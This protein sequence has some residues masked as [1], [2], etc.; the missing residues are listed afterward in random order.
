MLPFEGI[1]IIVIYHVNRVCCNTIHFQRII[2][3]ITVVD[4]TEEVESVCAFILYVK[5]KH[6]PFVGSGISDVHAEFRIHTGTVVVTFFRTVVVT[7][8]I[9]SAVIM[10]TNAFTS[11]VEIENGNLAGLRS[12]K[13]GTQVFII[14]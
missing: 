13:Y 7:C 3:T 4:R 6:L 1:P 5:G 9:V 11:Q 2:S 10:I 12:G 14:V 8:F